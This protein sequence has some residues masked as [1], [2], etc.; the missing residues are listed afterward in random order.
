MKYSEFCNIS[1]FPFELNLK[2]IHFSTGKNQNDQKFS[3]KVKILILNVNDIKEFQ[4][5]KMFS[6]EKKH[7]HKPYE[8]SFD[9]VSSYFFSPLLLLKLR[10]ANWN[11]TKNKEK[12]NLAS[13]LILTKQLICNKQCRQTEQSYLLRATCENCARFGNSTWKEIHSRTEMSFKPLK[14]FFPLY[15]VFAFHFFILFNEY[16]IFLLLKCYTKE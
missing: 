13:Q 1:S 4:S 5:K 9:T 6:Q 12:V 16:F 8:I 14:P 10:L 2:R 15:L 7:K 3:C 11:P